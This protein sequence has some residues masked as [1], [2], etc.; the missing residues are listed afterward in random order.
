MNYNPMFRV[1]TQL[2]NRY[3]ISDTPPKSADSWMAWHLWRTVLPLVFCYA[4]CN[5]LQCSQEYFFHKSADLGRVSDI[6]HLSA[7]WILTLASLIITNYKSF[8]SFES[9]L[10]QSARSTKSF[11]FFFS[12]HFSENVRK[13]IL[14]C[15][16]VHRCFSFITERRPRSSSEILTWLLH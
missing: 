7:N 2:A 10:F 15:S 3:K 4:F 5:V 6:F 1:S 11:S 8:P 12:K 9:S 13:T 16:F 14:F